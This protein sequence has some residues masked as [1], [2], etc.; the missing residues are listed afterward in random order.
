MTAEDVNAVLMQIADDTIISEFRA[1]DEN[2]VIE[3][4]N[5]RGLEFR[6]PTNLDAG[7]QAAPFA[8]LLLGNKTVV[9]QGAQPREADEALFQY[10]AVAGAISPASFRSA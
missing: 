10:V 5:I 2:G 3:F 7:T 1:S 6:F 9:V 4:T 8:D